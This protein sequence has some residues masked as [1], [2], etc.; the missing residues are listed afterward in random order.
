MSPTASFDPR[1]RMP[2]PCTAVTVVR[3]C[4]RGGGLGGCR[5]GVYR[6]G[7]WEG[8]TGSPD[9]LPGPIFSLILASGPYLRPNESKSKVIYE[10]SQDMASD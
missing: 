4:T 6:G 7:Y 2:R 1:D 3:G 8:Y 9:T 5:V 10:V